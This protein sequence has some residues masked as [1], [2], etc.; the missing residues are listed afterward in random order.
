MAL[1]ERREEFT[2]RR[3][4]QGRHR[5]TYW[6]SVVCC[7]DAFLS[8]LC[9][10]SLLAHMHGFAGGA[11]GVQ[12]ILLHHYGMETAKVEMCEEHGGAAF[13]WKSDGI[14]L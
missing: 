13:R 12:G 6:S 4:V 2:Q 8:F 1:A 5:R 10:V 9:F 7:R 3:A 14:T 11:Y